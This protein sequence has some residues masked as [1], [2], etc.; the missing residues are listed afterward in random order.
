ML[1]SE[2]YD[3]EYCQ[4][5]GDEL[6]ELFDLPVVSSDQHDTTP[7]KSKVPVDLGACFSFA[8][9]EP[10]MVGEREQLAC[11]HQDIKL[12]DLF[13]DEEAPINSSAANNGLAGQAP[14]NL[15]YLSMEIAASWH[16]RRFLSLALQKIDFGSARKVRVREKT[17]AW[18]AA[19]EPL[20][21]NPALDLLVCGKPKEYSWQ[22]GRTAFDIYC[23]IV[24]AHLG[25]SIRKCRVP[26]RDAWRK[27]SEQDKLKFYVLGIAILDKALDLEKLALRTEPSPEIRKEG[28]VAQAND[29]GKLPETTDVITKADKAVGVLLTYNT[30]IGLKD[31]GVHQILQ[32]CADNEKLKQ[33]YSQSPLHQALVARFREF[34]DKVAQ[35]TDSKSVAVSMELSEV[36]TRRGRVHLHAFVGAGIRA[37]TYNGFDNGRDFLEVDVCDLMFEGLVPHMSPCKP[38]RHYPKQKFDCV[39]NGLYYVLCKKAS[40]IFR[41]SNCWPIK[42]TICFLVFV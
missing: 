32:E 18:K 7:R 1:P 38:W 31:A 35:Q 29:K 37:T 5:F 40:T 22:V 24:G 21:E 39:A 8:D 13:V 11:Q 3:A 42:D 23:R 14:V 6:A 25:L 12:S 17:V 41:D 9:P 30:K 33:R 36:S 20:V 19:L 2:Q 15:N 27:A 34:I 4:I 10:A 16:P 26:L 28:E